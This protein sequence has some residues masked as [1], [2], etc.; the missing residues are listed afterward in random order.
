MIKTTQVK[1]EEFIINS[2]GS[3]SPKSK[4]ELVWGYDE[5]KSHKKLILVEES[6]Q[7]RLL[8]DELV[9]LE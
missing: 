3:I 7:R 4:P 1:P 8:F 9:D 6:D 2:N 5:T